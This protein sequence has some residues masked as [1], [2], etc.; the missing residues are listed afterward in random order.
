MVAFGRFI[1]LECIKMLR[2]TLIIQT[3]TNDSCELT[4]KKN[5]FFYR[6][7]KSNYNI[8]GKKTENSRPLKRYY[9]KS[10]FASR[11]MVTY[12]FLQPLGGKINAL[13]QCERVRIHTK[14]LTIRKFSQFKNSFWNNQ[15]YHIGC[16]NRYI[17]FV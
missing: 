2:I 5:N 3:F 16:T 13:W 10:T 8:F 15:K 6:G 12:R 17:C 7:K 1:Q 9:P 11:S 4:K 14:W